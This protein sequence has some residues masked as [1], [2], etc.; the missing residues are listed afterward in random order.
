MEKGLGHI[1]VTFR[2]AH[3]YNKADFEQ[4]L[5]KFV[6]YQNTVFSNSFCFRLSFVNKRLF[7]IEDASSGI[8]VN[9][10]SVFFCKLYVTDF[11]FQN[12]VI[13]FFRFFGLALDW[14]LIAFP[15]LFFLLLFFESEPRNLLKI[16]SS[17][18][19]PK[20]YASLL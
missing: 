14:F 18:S 17:N 7:S 2:S 20:I 19:I 3:F 12:V 15:D 5:F 9:S 4:H 16:S 13:M 8:L 1:F 6:I 11:N 10:D